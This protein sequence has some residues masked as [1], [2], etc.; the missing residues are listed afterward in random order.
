M[1]TTLVPTI[2]L[3]AMA[4]SYLATGTHIAIGGSAVVP[5]VGNGTT[6][7][8]AMGAELDR[9]ALSLKAATANIA[10]FEAFFTTTE[11]SATTTKTIRE[12]GLFSA[13]SGGTLLVHAQP[14]IPVEKTVNKTML[15]TVIV[16]FANA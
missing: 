4:T 13:L 11:P 12:V 16:T 15:V 2:G 9:N 8:I 6:T 3:T 1:A 14:V 7:G 5:I 10:T